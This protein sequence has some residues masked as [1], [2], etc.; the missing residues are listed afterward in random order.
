MS[1]IFLLGQNSFLA[2]IPPRHRN[3]ANLF[4]H[5]IM[6]FWKRPFPF[7]H[8]AV[9][10]NQIVT[11]LLVNSRF[12]ASQLQGLGLR[13]LDARIQFWERFAHESDEGSGQW[14]QAG[15]AADHDGDVAL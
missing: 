11:T 3:L 2:D 12:L 1:F 8:P 6:L 7:S 9:L 14:A 4:G 10:P 15:D 5:R 13:F